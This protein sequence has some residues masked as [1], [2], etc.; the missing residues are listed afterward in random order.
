MD[1]RHADAPLPAV[2]RRPAG[3][4]WRPWRISHAQ[5]LILSF[6]VLIL[7]GAGLL[8]LPAAQLR[9]VSALDSLFT[10]VSAA[11]LTGLATVPTAQSWSPF[12]QG[13]ILGLMQLGGIA[14]MS[15]G[16]LFAM[17]LGL[18][19]ALREHLNLGTERKTMRMRDALGVVPYVALV[20]LIIEAVGAAALAAR[21]ML[22]HQFSPGDAAVAGI[23]SAVSGFC[24][25]GFSLVNLSQPAFA[26]DGWLLGILALLIILG[27]LGFGVLVELGLTGRIRRLSLRARL[28]LVT[29]IAL[30]LVGFGFFLLFEW[31]NAATLGAEHVTPARKIITAG[32]LSATARSAGFS[33]LELTAL[34]PP[35][36]FMLGLLMLVG[37][38]PDSTGGGMKT[39]TLAVIVLA[40]LALLR[41][42]ADIE[43]FGRRIS[44]DMVRLALSLVCVYLF[45]VLLA[46]MAISLTQISL[47]S[48][49]PG[50]ETL[51]L[52]GA[53]MFEVVSAFGLSGLSMGVTP[54]LSPF[55]KA[56]IIACMV[57]GRVGPLLFIYSYA[58]PRRP[59]LR[60]LPAEMVMPG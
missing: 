10:A 25:G 49:P 42:R 46:I 59:R 9:P 41:R 53:L 29:T 24:N 12:G 4:A 32:F 8:L 13:V 21:F 50:P 18:R 37:A 52:Y 28:V 60:R 40:I 27:G 22:G 20:T 48:L 6:L 3:R 54:L 30:L 44:G 57:L 36:V 51:A 58:Q 33:T 16:V 7:L 47:Q 38:S 56:V 5:W 55:S 34:A 39:T 31:H 17:V 1:P 26:N 11:T 23:Y 45:A 43:I 2:P 15:F 14:A 35:T 19:V